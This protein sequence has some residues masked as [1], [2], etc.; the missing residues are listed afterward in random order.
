LI[1]PAKSALGASRSSRGTL[2]TVA[3]VALVPVG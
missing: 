1:E 3:G 2:L